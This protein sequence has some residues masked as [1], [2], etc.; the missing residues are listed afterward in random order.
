[1]LRAIAKPFGI[2][3]LQ[4]YKIFGN[5]G[6]AVILFALVVKVILL[7]FQMKS[8]RG[9][10]QQQ[11]LQPRMK[12]LEKKHGANKAKYNEEI[13]KLF[14]EEG[15]N[16][17]SGCLWS[18]IP[19]PILLALYYAIRYPL[20]IML[21]IGEQ[22]L[23]QGGALYERLSQVAR[24]FVGA[25]P[26]LLANLGLVA[27]ARPGAYTEIA[28]A[29]FIGEHID[30]FTNVSDKL[31]RINFNFLGMDLGRM[32]KWNFLWNTD[33][34]DS[35]VWLPE[36][37]LFLIPLLA[38]FLTFL[39]SR[40]S[41]KMSTAAPQAEGQSSMK[42]MMIIMP[43]MTV[44]F[45]FI[46]PSALGVYWLFSSV[47]GIIQDVWLTKR[48]SRIIQAESAA[49]EAQR[50]AKEAELEAKRLETER[51]RAAS[52]TKVNPSTSKRR[53]QETAKREQLARSAQW[54][55][56]NG[57]DGGGDGADPARVGERKYARGRAYDPLRFDGGGD[58]FG[59]PEELGESEEL[60]DPEEHTEP[61]DPGENTES[62]GYVEPSEYDAPDGYDE[63][64]ENGGYEE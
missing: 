6:L 64:G 28:Q 22:L 25:D 61:E 31:L 16:P 10:M 47:F 43:F 45:G 54:E 51:L 57:R 46:V 1:M 35:G 53:Q 5:Y 29:Q 23:A 8:K 15:V 7:P 55:R 33:W 37:G 2:L 32:A 52:A 9:M 24:E 39:Q 11:L 21:G 40:I 56:E 38:G 4:L 63:A 17:A 20:T 36:F 18:F 49:K 58:G 34:G 59:E 50:A 27:D 12:E 41:S 3:L 19:L 26:N 48:Y 30:R 60:G 13:A 62:D 44:Y 14:R 42:T